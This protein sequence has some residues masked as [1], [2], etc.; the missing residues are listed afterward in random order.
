MQV[1]LWWWGVD[2]Y[3]SDD[4]ARVKACH[5]SYRVYG[6]SLLAL[7]GHRPYEPAQSIRL[8]WISIYISKEGGTNTTPTITT[9]PNNTKTEEAAQSITLVDL[10]LK[11]GNKRTLIITN[12]VVCR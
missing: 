10:Y 1:Y 8:W 12:L 5:S 11:R 9:I 4:E 6:E 2:D 3:L 7:L